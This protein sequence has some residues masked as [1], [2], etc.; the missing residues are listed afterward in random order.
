MDETLHHPVVHSH[1]VSAGF[2]SQTWAYGH[3]W[4]YMG[5]YGHL[6]TFKRDF[7]VLLLLAIWPDLSSYIANDN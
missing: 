5:M 7:G 1:P 3:I 2:P 6:T 4:A